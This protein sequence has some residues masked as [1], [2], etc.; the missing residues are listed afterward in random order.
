MRYIAKIIRGKGRGERINFP[1]LNLE[2]PKNFSFRHGIY[3]G[4]VFIGE[5][6]YQG[7]FHFGPIPTFGEEKI[8]L[9]VF[10]LDAVISDPPPQISFELAAYLRAIAQFKDE[11]VLAAQIAED[12]E[13]TKRILRITE[14]S[15]LQ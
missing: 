15:S 12:V 1:T 4:W 14:A 6:K 3:A 8:S 9:E 13:E 10:V 11:K 5:R 2:I 7:S